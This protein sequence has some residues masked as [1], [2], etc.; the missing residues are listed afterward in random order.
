MSD[1]TISYTGIYGDKAITL[2]RNLITITTIEE[3]GRYYNWHIKPHTH[4]GLFQLFIVE[5][6]SVEILFA[7]GRRQIEGPAYFTVPKNIFHGLNL[8]PGMS[9]WVISLDDSSLENMLK[10]D[11]DIIF[12]I[13]E[14]Q[15]VKIVPGD[16]LIADAY[17]TMHKCIDE[18]N[19][20]LPAKNLALQYLVGMLLLR[21]YRI[22]HSAKESIRSSENTDKIYYRRFN[23]LLKEYNSPH[24]GLDDY[25]VLLGI[26][27]GH[28]NR[29]CKHVSGQSPKDIIIGHFIHEAKSGLASLELS[30]AEVS[31]SLHF[32]DPGYFSRLFKKK[33][34][35]TPKE[36]RNSI[37]LT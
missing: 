32:E 3:K 6:G 30:I 15:I 12:A 19:N 34:G 16:T 2:V 8:Q 5:K 28:L 35:L 27:T 20:R 17:A 24:K 31:Y 22:P 36:Y 7:D 25:A 37:S 10:L 14:I 29:I 33:T 21:L 9:G 1:N 13:D 18:F 4:P 23:Q 26:T 11:A